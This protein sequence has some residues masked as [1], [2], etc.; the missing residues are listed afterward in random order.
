MAIES[1]LRLL[2]ALIQGA[3]DTIEA[4]F[5]AESVEFPA[6]E[7]PFDPA[8]T[9]ESVLLEPEMLAATA[10][11]VAAASQLIAMVRSPVQTLVEHSMVV[12][13]ALG[14]T[15]PRLIIIFVTPMT[16]STYPPASGRRR[17][18]TWWRSS[19]RR[20]R[21]YAVGFFSLCLFIGSH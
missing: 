17:K 1:H 10:Q 2:G 20:G 19:A 15:Y 14:S 11:I 6:L 18:A 8:G 3:I 5:E 9:A 7:V 21:W 12:R 16:S 13:P 4:R